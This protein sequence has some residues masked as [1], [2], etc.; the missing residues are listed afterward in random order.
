MKD[1][2]YSTERNACRLNRVGGQAVL[3]GVMM[4][5]GERTVTTCRKEDGSLVVDD[6]KFVSVREKHKILNIPILRGVVN[7]VEMMLLSVKT[8]GVSA[9]AL[10]IEEEEGKAEK[11]LKSLK[12][13]FRDSCLKYQSRRR[14][15]IK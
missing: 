14:L 1:K 12:N 13:L 8:L 2:K 4:K 3:E 11:W 10:G 6:S 5:A 15:V 9:D 7:F